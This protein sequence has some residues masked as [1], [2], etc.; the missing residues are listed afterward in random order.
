MTK[1]FFYPLILYKAA[2]TLLCLLPL[3][4]AITRA[5]A[6]IA[7]CGV[8]FFFLLNSLYNR[9]WQWTSYVEIRVLGALWLWTLISSLLSPFD[10]WES[11]ISALTWGRF[12]LFFAAVR[13]WLFVSARDLKIANN[14]RVG[15]IA[16]RRVAYALAIRNLCA[17]CAVICPIFA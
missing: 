14:I 5:G 9:D 6:D 11:F 4:L 10:V 1:L 15:R 2:F 16:I 3:L 17:R 8:G 12:I 7:L 13:C